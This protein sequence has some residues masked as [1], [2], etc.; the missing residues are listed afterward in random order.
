MSDAPNLRER[1][2]A[3]TGRIRW[4][5]L[6]RHF[7]RG[8]TVT[9]APDLDLVEVAVCFVDDDTDRVQSWLERG[10]VAR[11]GDDEARRWSAVDAEL[12]AVVVPPWVLVQEPRPAHLH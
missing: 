9:V 4:S 7:A 6:E 10:E 2:N 11:T 1:L 12:W 3:E 8:A 5:E